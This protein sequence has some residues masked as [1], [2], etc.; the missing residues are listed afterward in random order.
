M[1]IENL[2][3]IDSHFGIIVTKERAITRW[4]NVLNN[5]STAHIV[6]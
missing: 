3:T 1:I 4:E 6:K 5:N 2:C